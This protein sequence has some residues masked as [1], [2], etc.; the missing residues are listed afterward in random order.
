MSNG[1]ENNMAHNIWHTPQMNQNPVRRRSRENIAEMQRLIDKIGTYTPEKAFIDETDRYVHS[2]RFTDAADPELEQHH[3]V[4][5]AEK[6]TP[7]PFE[8]PA[9]GNVYQAAD[10]SVS[11]NLLTPEQ[12]AE[13]AGDRERYGSILDT[14]AYLNGNTSRRASF[15]KRVGSTQAS[16]QDRDKKRQDYI[17]RAVGSLIMKYNPANVGELKTI[18][19]AAGITD[20]DDIKRAYEVFEN[21]KP[22]EAQSVVD[23]ILFF[24]S[25]TFHDSAGQTDT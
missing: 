18:L 4:V 2:A 10:Q 20:V 19:I 24:I 21:F 17:D 25:K 8:V 11:S 9:L 22:L 5:Q 16:R 13:L 23:H 7:T 14:L 1:G 6:E 15:E 12:Q 3:Q